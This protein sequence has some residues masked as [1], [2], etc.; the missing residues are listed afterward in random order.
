MAE[1]IQRQMWLIPNSLLFPT[2]DFLCNWLSSL[3]LRYRRWLTGTELLIYVLILLAL[4]TD[5]SSLCMLHKKKKEAT[6]LS[7]LLHHP[8]VTCI[9]FFSWRSSPFPSVSW[10]L[11][12]FFRRT[13]IKPEGVCFIQGDPGPGPI[14]DF[15]ASPELCQA[16]EH[17]LAGCTEPLAGRPQ[18]HSST[19]GRRS[20]QRQRTPASEPVA[21]G[22]GEWAG[23]TQVARVVGGAARLELHP[24]GP[25]RNAFPQLLALDAPLFQVLKKIN[26]IKQI[27][28]DT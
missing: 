3:W 8:M 25:T 10:A 24:G 13:F 4:R 9:F 2:Y 6:T 20:H 14:V 1:R 19:V 26:S 22:P 7:R 21:R 11:L 16:A 27:S 5:A 17:A 28:V 23:A 12:I 15:T 18:T